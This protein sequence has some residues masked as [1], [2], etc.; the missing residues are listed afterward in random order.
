MRRLVAKC[1]G[2]RVVGAI[3]TTLAPQ[4]LGYGIPLGSEA[5]AR[6]ARCYLENM[7]PGQAVI[8]L[9]FKNAFN[10]LRRDKV[11]AAVRDVAPELF[12]FV[13]SAYQTPSSL[14]CGDHVLQSEEGVQQGDPLGPLLFCLTIH[15]LVT[16]LTSEFKVFYLDDGTLG[17]SAESVLH[18]LQL[19]ERE[20]AEL[21]LQLNCSKSE[22][23]CCDSSSRDAILSEAPGLLIT[24]CDQAMLLGSPLGGL[25]GIG[26]AIKQ[27]ADKLELMGERLGVMQSQDALLLLRHSFAIPKMLYVLRT[28]PCFLS[29]ELEMFDNML[30]NI[31][32]SIVNV[33]MASEPAWL[34]ASLPV[35]AGGVGI[36]RTV[37]L[38]PS[39]FLASAAGCSELIHNILPPRLH[40]IND[41][42]T[43]AALACWSGHHDLPPPT[44]PESHYQRV[45]D[46]TRIEATFQNLVE[47]AQNQ[48]SQARLLAVACPESGAWLNALPISSIGLR[49]E[50]EV[51][52]VAVGLR[53][54]LPLG[55]SHTC[56]SCGSEV[57]ELGTHGLSCRFSKGRH[58]RHAAVNDIIRRALDSARIPSHIEPLGLYRS[59][60]KRPDGATVVPWKY[61][62]VL[63]WDATCTDTLAPSHRALAARE[64]RAVAADAEQRKR[65]KYAHLDHTHFFV[66]VAVETLGAMGT[67]A[68][69]FF[70]EVARHIARVTNEPRSYQY[71]L[72]RV[73]V[74]IQRGNTDSV[75]GAA[76]PGDFL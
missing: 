46:S 30:R 71:L 3:S 4:Q 29:S 47:T 17:G 60:G 38:A 64:P 69:A 76:S 62:R 66:P 25:E 70:K 26:Y 5:A 50:D 41:P 23:I 63:V 6:A 45:W 42:H 7:S 28:A 13:Y 51:V 20:A 8:K 9:D 67:E 73:A 15:P 40:N 14:F 32:S 27:K 39:A 34:Q 59:D 53:L 43:E 10:C 22:L 16:K 74:A 65:V 18:D 56:S 58:S 48:Q 75:L 55:C 2:S 24:S 1:A 54:G 44:A 12:Q 36:R 52:R 21:G 31:F 72:Q 35:R 11:M 68:L 49:M 57:D 33:S 37:Q 61:G 19:V